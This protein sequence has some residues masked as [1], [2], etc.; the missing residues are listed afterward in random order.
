MHS[1]EVRKLHLPFYIQFCC[2]LLCFPYFP[3]FCDVCHHLLLI[4]S[5][6][7]FPFLKPV[8]SGSASAVNS[9][10]Q[11]AFGIHARK[12]PRP[13][14]CVSSK[15][16]HAGLPFFDFDTILCSC[17]RPSDEAVRIYTISCL[18]QIKKNIFIVFYIVSYILS[19]FL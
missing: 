11:T 14:C 12:C 16:P 19:P 15:I 18:V 7:A 6:P 1:L 17:A 4:P 3:P 2:F 9:V 5:T 8:S 13:A 10:Q